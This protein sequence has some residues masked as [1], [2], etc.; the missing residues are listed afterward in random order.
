MNYRIAV[1][2]GGPSSEHHV[3]L[4]TGKAVMN[5]LSDDYMVIDIV[6]DK[7]GYW[8]RNGICYKPAKAL[9]DI[10]VVFN[11]MHG[12]YGEDGRVQQILQAIKKPFTG[13]KALGAVL[14]INKAKAKDIYKNHGLKT[15]LHL[16]LERENFLNN[17]DAVAIEILRK[18][19]LPLIVKPVDKGSSLGISVVR[20]FKSLIETLISLFVYTDKVLIEEYIKGKEGTIGVIEKFRGQEIYPLLPVEIVFTNSNNKKDFFDHDSKYSGETKYI[21]PGAFSKKE[22]EEI[23]KA[24]IIAHKELGLRHY[25]RTDF[26]VHPRRGI[27]ILETNS[28]PGLTSTSLL[29]ISLEAVGS[30]YKEFLNHVITLAYNDK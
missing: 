30:N 6:I 15:P 20:D 21:C 5:T 14:S 27:F 11:A 18:I 2:R 26:I 17:T 19:P 8:Y 24:G 7:K 16:V 10:D 3:S 13:P 4:K 23:L 29:P 25:S 22:K 12:E 28:L 1:L 9:K